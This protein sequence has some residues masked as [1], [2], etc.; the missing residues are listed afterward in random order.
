[1]PTLTAESLSQECD[2]CK[3]KGKVGKNLTNKDGWYFC[4]A[5]LLEIEK[6]IKRRQ[7]NNI[8]D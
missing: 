7:A 5:C 4:V 3:K 6:E 1:M 2:F 8:T